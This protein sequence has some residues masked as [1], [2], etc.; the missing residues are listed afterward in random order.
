MKTCSKCNQKKSFKDFPFRSKTKKY[1]AHCRLCENAYHVAR[2]NKSQNAKQAHRKLVKDR[3]DKIRKWIWSLKISPC[4]DCKISFSS[5]QM[6]FD[7]KPGEEKLD[8]VSAMISSGNRQCILEEI[9]KCDLVCANCHADRTYKRKNIS[10]ELQQYRTM[11]GSR[12]KR[13]LHHESL[14]KW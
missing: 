2:R 13:N 1:M 3:T 4:M 9:K 10:R 7:H 8:D 6:H 12:Y 5:W 11:G 14:V